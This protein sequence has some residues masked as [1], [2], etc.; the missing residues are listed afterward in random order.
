MD[1]IT[2]PESKDGRVQNGRSCATNTWETD[3]SRVVHMNSGIRKPQLKKFFRLMKF[4]SRMKT[5]VYYVRLQNIAYIEGN[6]Y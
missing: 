5:N 3:G 6:N 2:Y 1:V 4:N